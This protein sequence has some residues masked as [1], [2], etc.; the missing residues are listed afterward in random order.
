M[1]NALVQMQKL[2]NQTQ[3]TLQ[4]MVNSANT[5]Q[6]KY[7][8]QEAQKA[9]NW[10]EKMSKT[11]HQMEVAD[12]KKAGLNPVLSS[13]GSGAQSY[14][15]SSAS[16]T[17]E[18]GASGL[19]NVQSSQLTAIGS[20]ESSRIQAAAQRAAAA[21]SAAAMRA[22]AATSAA[23]QR[24]AANVG[25]AKAKYQADIQRKNVITQTKT[26]KWIAVNKPTS[27][28]G[29]LDKYLTKTGIGSS[30]SALIRKFVE[31]GQSAFKSITKNN[32]VGFSNS[33]K[34]TKANFTLNGQ[35]ISTVNRFLRNNGLTVNARNR[36]LATKAFVFRDQ[37]AFNSLAT[38]SYNR[39]RDR[40][41]VRHVRR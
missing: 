38:L 32:G 16:A 1:A 15:T 28:G 20:M 22:A 24:Y 39:S 34:I 17:P 3:V 37:S 14:T 11:A 25:Y 40:S 30:G 13:G 33:G 26:Q 41:V 29:L 36:K 18:S 21:Q 23:A 19:S 27:I 5:L 31:R 9:R 7:N 8:S 10:Q 6:T 4:K 35:G 2:A 12:L